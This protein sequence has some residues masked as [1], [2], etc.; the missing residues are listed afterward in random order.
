MSLLLI[1]RTIYASAPSK[2][3]EADYFY[4]RNDETRATVQWR[5]PLEGTAGF[6]LYVSK[7]NDGAAEAVHQLQAA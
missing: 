3:R 5:P 2:K 7:Y 1:L 6:H 4:H